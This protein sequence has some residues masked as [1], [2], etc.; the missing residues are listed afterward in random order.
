MMKI[1]YSFI[2][3]RGDRSVNEDAIG[4]LKKD[5]SLCFILCD[6]LGGHG[7][8]D[9]ASNLAVETFEN[10][11]SL[12]K[13]NKKFLSA[14]F[15]LAQKNILKKQEELRATQ[16]MKTTA[17]ALAIEKNKSFV[18]HIGDSRLYLFNDEKMVFRTTDHTVAQMMVLSGEIEESEIRNNPDRNILL[19]SLGTKWTKPEYEIEKTIR[20]KKGYSFLLCSD[21]FWELI[22]ER[23][24]I[25]LLN[26][27][28]SARQWL[29]E[30]SKIVNTNGT[31]INMD[32]YSAIAVWCR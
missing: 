28:K 21:G 5:E 31:N 9:V 25:E 4:C 23:K 27:T 22:D 2:T 14:S 24:M 26:S 18:G 11:F 3:D 30:M 12:M 17:V 1:D 13:S 6:G 7:M 10:T 8:G 29:E 32:N 15:D 16:K 19:K 20:L